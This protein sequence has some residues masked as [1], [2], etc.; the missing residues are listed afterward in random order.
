MFREVQ[1]YLYS[2]F[3]NTMIHPLIALL[4]FLFLEPLHDWS[5]GKW[6]DFKKKWAR[7]LILDECD[8]IQTIPYDAEITKNIS[9][10]TGLTISEVRKIRDDIKFK[11]I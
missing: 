11:G 2:N 5:Y 1:N 9:N 10:T 6:T 3:H 7:E 8:R 4:P